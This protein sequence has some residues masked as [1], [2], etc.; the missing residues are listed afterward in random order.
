MVSAFRSLG[1]EIGGADQSGSALCLLLHVCEGIQHSLLG[2][3]SSSSGKKKLLSV[4]GVHTHAYLNPQLPVVVCPLPSERSI[5][6]SHP[7][8]SKASCGHD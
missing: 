6:L 2:F 5:L 3:L 4:S 7:Q 1:E 8:Q